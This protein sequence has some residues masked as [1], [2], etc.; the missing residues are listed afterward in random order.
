[1]KTAESPGVPFEVE[2]SVYH[3]EDFRQGIDIT[4]RKHSAEQSRAAD[5][6]LRSADHFHAPPGVDAV[7]AR[8]VL[9]GHDADMS[10]DA[11]NVQRLHE[12]LADL[13]EQSLLA[14]LVLSFALNDVEHDTR[15]VIRDSASTG[16]SDLGSE[17]ASERLPCCSS[18]PGQSALA[19]A[20]RNGGRRSVQAHYTVLS[21]ASIRD[22]VQELHR[23]GEVVGSGN[24]ILLTNDEYSPAGTRCVGVSHGPTLS[25]P[26]PNPGKRCPT[27][28]CAC[29]MRNG[30]SGSG[31][32]RG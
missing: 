12:R 2:S 6:S 4:Q 26:R 13:R 8:T 24:S 22:S 17:P 14:D 25:L 10:V 7:L 19:T 30:V 3:R 20:H 31:G 29:A 15:V 27:L 23:A 32:S 1:M 16:R 11:K 9:A 5:R 21:E 28:L 18:K